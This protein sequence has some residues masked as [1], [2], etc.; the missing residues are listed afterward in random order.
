MLNPTAS[1]TAV[2][3][4]YNTRKLLE[5]CL[6]SLCEAVEGVV[7]LEIIIVDNGSTDGS[8][9]YVEATRICGVTP[10]FNT[11][12]VGFARANNQA[13]ALA[14]TPYLL[15]LNSDAFIEREAIGRGL[16]LLEDRPEIGMVG[17]RIDNPDGSVQ[18]EYGSFPSLWDDVCTSL[19]FD[20]LQAKTA[21][22]RMSRAVPVDWVQGACMFVRRKA[23]DDVG[24]LDTGYFMYSE[25]VDWCRRFWK[26]GWQVWYEPGVSVAHIGSASSRQRGLQRRAALYRSRLGFRRKVG[27]PVAS[28]V[29]WLAMLTGLFGRIIIRMLVQIVKRG[30][31]G[32]QTVRSDWALLGRI[33]RMDPLARWTVS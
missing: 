24:G 28:A 20:Q 11:T 25:E 5:R 10:I 4:S 18:A 15:L 17:M 32:R 6:A 1:L 30:P 3:V 27:G 16:E 26:A 33:V 7:Q 9:E 2:I 12:N 19:G 13:L 14:E 8:A 22:S 21:S 23:I 31:V 29:L